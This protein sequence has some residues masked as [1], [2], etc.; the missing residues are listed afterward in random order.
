MLLSL[1]S[2]ALLA[3]CGDDNNDGGGGTPTVVEYQGVFGSA[4]NAGRITFA[5]ATAD[6]RANRA[7]LVAPITLT[8]QLDFITGTV[9]T[10][11]G[12][13]DGTALVL[14]GSGYDFTGT[15]NGDVINGV[16][17]G[18]SGEAGNFTA[19]LVPDGGFV[20]TMC[21]TYTGDDAGV[22]SLTLDSSRDGGAII[23]PS[24]NTGGVTAL[25]RPKS[26]TTDQFEVLPDLAPTFVLAT[27]T[28]NSTFNAVS[29][30]WDD[31]AGSSGT[32]TGS[33]DACI[34]AN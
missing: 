2:L 16:F 20:V 9:V 25:A 19:S 4:T 28:V 12:T 32:F 3:G 5:T 22:F 30:T 33:V 6:L 13:L 27:G 1:A 18:P 34:P 26:G 24:D 10:L 8:G 21:G 31:G 7:A 17:T 14:T 11:T 23:V 29:G 15:Q